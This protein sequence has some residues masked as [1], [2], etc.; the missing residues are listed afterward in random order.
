MCSTVR[1]SDNSLSV[2]NDNAGQSGF[3]LLRAGAMGP[4]SVFIMSHS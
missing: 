2:C 3:S 1:N 4:G